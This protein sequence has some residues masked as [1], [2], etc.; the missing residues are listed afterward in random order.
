VTAWKRR[1]AP[2]GVDGSV[3]PGRPNSGR[4]RA[5]SAGR[6]GPTAASRLRSSGDATCSKRIDPEPERHSPRALVGATDQD[7]GQPG[8]AQLGHEPALADSRFPEDSDEGGPAATRLVESG[9]QHGRLRMPT[10]Q[11]RLFAV[12]H[13]T[14]R[15]RSCGG[16]GY[17]RRG[18]R[19]LERL[20]VEAASLSSGRPLAHAPAPARTP[21]IGATRRPDGPLEVE[22]HQRPVRRLLQTGRGPGSAASYGSP[23]RAGRR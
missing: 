21:G 8:F 13:P 12:A 1:T 20:S 9:P 23:A 6:S 18:T 11:Q 19:R 4:S 3:S 7:A 17:R 10:N 15:P 16:A 14:Q 5:S 2:S 22:T